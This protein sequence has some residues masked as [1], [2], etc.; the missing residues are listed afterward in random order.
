MFTGALQVALETGVENGPHALSFADV[1]DRVWEILQQ[2]YANAAIRP[3]LYAPDQSEGDLSQQ[4]AFPNPLWRSHVENGVMESGEDKSAE[5]SLDSQSLLWESE[6][7]ADWRLHRNTNRDT[8]ETFFSP[9]DVK[10]VITFVIWIVVLTVA[11]SDNMALNQ[12]AKECAVAFAIAGLVSF[13]VHPQPKRAVIFAA[14]FTAF[15]SLEGAFE[16]VSGHYLALGAP[17][18]FFL[19]CIGTASVL[20]LTVGPW[21]SAWLCISYSIV[22]VGLQWATLELTG[23][24]RELANLNVESLFESSALFLLPILLVVTTFPILSAAILLATPQYRISWK[25]DITHTWQSVVRWTQLTVLSLIVLVIIH[26]PGIWSLNSKIP[27]ML[28]CTAFVP[29]LASTATA[30]RAR[31]GI[32]DWLKSPTR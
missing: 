14:I 20:N 7:V 5:A 27:I 29:F 3:V 19:G 32:L 9:T 26:I 21:P 23:F 4:P 8:L 11:L 10:L 24:A 16:V 25:T 15:Y 22:G 17:F 28:W 6:Q 30:L 31:P 13:Q 18:R 1:R 12:I 2:K